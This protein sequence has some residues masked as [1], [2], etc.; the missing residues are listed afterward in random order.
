[1]DLEEEEGSF[2]ASF[3]LD[4][5]RRLAFFCEE[6]PPKR[7]IHSLL[8]KCTTFSVV[9]KNALHNGGPVVAG[10][11]NKYTAR[12]ENVD[13]SSQDHHIQLL[14]L[15]CDVFYQNFFRNWIL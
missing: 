11:M 10:N 9:I 1:M 13:A 7:H 2:P 5:D 6:E 15:F 3:P 4:P 14:T 8:H 12:L